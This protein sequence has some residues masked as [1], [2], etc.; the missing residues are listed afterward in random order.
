[1]EQIDFESLKFIIKESV[2]KRALIT[3]HSRGDMDSVASAVALSGYLKGAVV[4]TPDIISAN[5]ARVLRHFGVPP[6][7]INNTFP[8]KPDMVIMLDVN[9][10]EDCGPFKYHLE[11]FQG[12]ILVVD[13]HVKRDIRSP[14]V[15]IFNDEGYNSASSIV[16]DLLQSLEF[17]LGPD[18]AGLL[19]AGILSDSADLKN[20]MAGTFTQIGRLLR[21]AGL[22]Y[23]EVMDLL[24]HVADPAARLK[25]INDIRGAEME[26]RGD[27]LLMHGHAHAHANIAADMGIKIGADLAIFYTDNGSEVSFSARLRPPLDKRYGIHLGSIMQALSKHIN[28][29]GGGHPAAAGAYGPPS[30]DPKLFVAEVLA[31]VERRLPDGKH[32][33]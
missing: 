25:T 16:F 23:V 29:S 4:A 1:M 19:L 9:N 15:T 21:T 27:F 7:S 22:D 11:E 10:F 20:S 18:T 2:G 26:I 14:N 24:N 32:N 6:E 5:A 31:E 8:P 13:H 33:R 17:K 12:Q 30:N 3:F 28:G